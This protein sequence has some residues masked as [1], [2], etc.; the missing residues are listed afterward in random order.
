MLHIEE[1]SVQARIDG[2][3]EIFFRVI[4]KVGAALRGLSVVHHNV[5]FAKM[6]DALCDSRLDL[7]LVGALGNGVGD[8]GAVFALKLF[9]RFGQTPLGAAGNK[10]ACTLFGERARNAETDS[11]AAA[12]DN[13]DLSIQ[14]THGAPLSIVFLGM[15]QRKWQ[16]GVGKA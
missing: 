4:D 15:L 12:G 11:L 16:F 9:S 5:K 14:K 1:G 3:V 6:L 10:Q 13:G 2:Q 8:I 7:G